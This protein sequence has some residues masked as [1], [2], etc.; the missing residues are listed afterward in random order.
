MSYYT[1]AYAH[2]S[3][4]LSSDALTT[5]RSCIPMIKTETLEN[6]ANSRFDAIREMMGCITKTHSKLKSEIFFNAYGNKNPD[7]YFDTIGIGIFRDDSDGEIVLC[8]TEMWKVNAICLNSTTSVPDKV[9]VTCSYSFCDASFTI[10]NAPVIISILPDDKYYHT[11]QPTYRCESYD[12]IITVDDLSTQH[13]QSVIVPTYAAA[14]VDLKTLI[15]MDLNIPS[16]LADFEDNHTEPLW[17]TLQTIVPNGILGYHF[18]IYRF[19]SDSA[20]DDWMFMDF[21]TSHNLVMFK[22]EAKTPEEFDQLVHRIT[23]HPDAKH[24]SDIAKSCV[25]GLRI[26]QSM[27]SFKEKCRSA[28]DLMIVP[29]YTD[30]ECLKNA[31]TATWHSNQLDSDYPLGHF[32]YSTNDQFING[33]M[34]PTRLN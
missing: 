16:M 25:S 9:V 28:Y 4:G 34:L 22:M 32:V 17:R 7:Y 33:T 18:N 19:Y 23:S 5:V 11:A 3:F 27:E 24:G 12:R 10:N 6:A 1:A 2:S 30:P 14:R 26:Y 21:E 8:G 13:P 15:Q 20:H 29:N 31:F